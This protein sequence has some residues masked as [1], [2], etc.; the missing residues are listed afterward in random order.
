MTFKGHV[1]VIWGV[2]IIKPDLNSSFKLSSV[3]F[4][5]LYVSKTGSSRF[6]NENVNWCA[7]WTIWKM[8]LD[9]RAKIKAERSGHLQQS[10]QPKVAFEKTIQ[11]NDINRLLSWLFTLNLTPNYDKCQMTNYLLDITLCSVQ[12]SF[13]SCDI[14]FFIKNFIFRF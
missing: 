12:L 6:W 14:I 3:A 5:F 13:H 2:K 7:K 9:G 4:T 10:V 8:K 11:F 1:E